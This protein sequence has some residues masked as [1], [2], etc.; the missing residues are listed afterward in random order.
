MTRKGKEKEPQQ[1]TLEQE[2]IRTGVPAMS[3]DLVMRFSDDTSQPE[4]FMDETVDLILK[5][6]IKQ[7]GV[8][9]VKINWW[10]KDLA[11]IA[12]NDIPNR[13]ALQGTQEAPQSTEESNPSPIST[14]EKE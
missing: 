12:P 14:Q 4:L 1:F 13:N 6:L 5:G 7:Y 9:V 10:S 11:V 3:F 2:I 8:I